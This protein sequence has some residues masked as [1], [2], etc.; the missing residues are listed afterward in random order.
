[1]D[2]RVGADWRHGDQ[3]SLSPALITRGAWR[4]QHEQLLSG[5]AELKRTTS[6]DHTPPPSKTAGPLAGCLE[7][8]SVDGRRQQPLLQGNLL[9]SSC[10]SY[11][12]LRVPP[13]RHENCYFVRQWRTSTAGDTYYLT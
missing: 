6:S 13:L 3:P 4:H 8:R 10:T 11:F 7:S 2:S 5:P 12:V 1:M 9:F